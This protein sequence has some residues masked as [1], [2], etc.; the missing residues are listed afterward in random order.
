MSIAHILEHRSSC[1]RWHHF[2]SI[3]ASGANARAKIFC[4]AT[5]IRTTK[6]Q[7]R[8]CRFR[9]HFRFDNIKILIL[10]TAQFCII[11]F[12]GKPS[13]L[14][15][16]ERTVTSSHITPKFLVTFDGFIF[17]FACIWEGTVC[18]AIIFIF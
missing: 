1:E 18:S 12:C 4:P 7:Q 2:G 11:K 10:Y 5:G 16:N 8:S 14:H 9:K 17:I 13:I 6:I 15:S 3:A